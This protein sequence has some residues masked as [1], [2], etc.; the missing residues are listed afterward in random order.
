MNVIGTVI[1]TFEGTPSSREFSFVII[2]ED[3]AKIPIRKGQ[4]VQIETDDGFLIARVSEIM[5]TN[6]YFMRAES[7]REFERAGRPLMEMFPVERWEYLVANAVTLG[8]YNDGKQTR[9]SFPPSPGDK[10]CRIEEKILH[11]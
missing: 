11:E 6:R 9:V 7:V 5:K 4:F 8:I 10:V 2:K 3:L 1:S